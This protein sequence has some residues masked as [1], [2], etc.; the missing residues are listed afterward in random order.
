MVEV[1]D[2]LNEMNK[3]E[4]TETNISNI[5]ETEVRVS[6]SWCWNSS[7]VG[8]SKKDGKFAMLAGLKLPR[9]EDAVENVEVMIWWLE[10]GR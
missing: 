4:N 10:F 3:N 5:L 1:D 2:D 8:K 9:S 6:N 7:G